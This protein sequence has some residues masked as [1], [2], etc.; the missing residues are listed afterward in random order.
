MHRNATLAALV[1]VLLIGLAPR[2][3]VLSTGP[4]TIVQYVPDDA[5]YYFQIARHIV[6]GNGS[7]FDGVYMTNG[8]H[9]LWMSLL[10]PFAAFFASPLAFLKAG[11]AAA[12]ACNLI[13]AVLLYRLVRRTTGIGWL[14]VAGSAAYFLNSQAI[15]SSLDGLETSVSSLLFIVLLYL[16]LSGRMF[17]GDLVHLARYGIIL[18]LLFLS[19]TDNVFYL[20]AFFLVALFQIPQQHRLSRSAVLLGGVALIVSPWLLWNMFDFGAIV[21]SSGFAYPYLQH[22]AYLNEGHT[23]WQMWLWSLT[24]F[25]LYLLMWFNVHLGFPFVFF[26]TTLTFSLLVIA[27]RRNERDPQTR[28]AVWTIL[29]LWVAGILL[30]FVHTF[31]RW[32]PRVWYFDQLIVLSAFTFCLAFAF[33]DLK[34]KLVLLVRSIE[35][36]LPDRAVWRKTVGAIAVIAGAASIAFLVFTSAI[37]PPYPHQIEMLDAAEWLHENLGKG[38]SAAA[39]NAGIMAFFSGRR[40]VNLDGVVNNAAYAAILNV[41][42]ARLLYD[43]SARYYLDFDPVMLQLYA[44]FFGGMRNRV[45]MV[46]VREIDRP[47]VNWAGASIRVYR[48]DRLP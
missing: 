38:E 9:P 29:A 45:K 19:R 5:F 25:V 10:L 37:Q 20:A 36:R 35:R 18:G 43:S 16:T 33:L 23:T 46:A 8:Y 22:V 30:V 26:Q 11:L 28:L 12:I 42:L 7:T 1:V 2:L 47:G 40:V 14:A 48:L 15:L 34:R 27:R 4:G 13:C 44:P 21:Q 17:R 24:Y 41:D 39:F 31:V 32:Y 3:W 6:A